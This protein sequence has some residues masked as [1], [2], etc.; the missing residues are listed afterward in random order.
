MR[1]RSDVRCRQSA[2]FKETIEALEQKIDAALDAI[3]EKSDL[4]LYFDI[5]DEVKKYPLIADIIGDRYR[6]EGG[7]SVDIVYGGPNEDRLEL[8]IG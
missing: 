2:N 6:M 3:D 8:E 4:P 5:H 7:F 1:K